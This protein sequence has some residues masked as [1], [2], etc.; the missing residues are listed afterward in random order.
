MAWQGEGRGGERQS[1]WG[2][3]P[4]LRLQQE[5]M[6]GRD[7]SVLPQTLPVCPLFKKLSCLPGAHTLSDLKVSE[8][9]CA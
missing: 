7:C 6:E 5:L 1:F 9:E 2:S 3:W 4:E 8:Q